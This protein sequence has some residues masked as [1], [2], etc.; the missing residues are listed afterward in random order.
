MLYCLSGKTALD[1]I[2][3]A[4]QKKNTV[5]TTIKTTNRFIRRLNMP[6]SII[7]II[8]IIKVHTYSITITTVMSNEKKSRAIACTHYNLGGVEDFNGQEDPR[9]VYM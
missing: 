5:R 2:M 6:I 8:I 4:V 7:I 1:Y 3:S 9:C